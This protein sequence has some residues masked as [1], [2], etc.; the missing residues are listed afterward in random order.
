MT[1]AIFL[2]GL[3][4]VLFVVGMALGI[5][6]GTVLFDAHVVAQMPTPDPPKAGEPPASSPAERPSQEIG[7]WVARLDAP[8]VQLS[9]TVL[10]GIAIRRSAPFA[11]CT[12]ATHSS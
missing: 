7:S 4:R 6:C 11:T 5:W 1:A 9:A 2:R 12:S 3:E 10:E 8:T